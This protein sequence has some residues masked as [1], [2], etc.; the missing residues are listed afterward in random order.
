MTTIKTNRFVW[1]VPLLIC[2]GLF[3]QS[4]RGTITGVVT[5]ASGAVVP[6][7]KV[8]IT[9]QA[10]N[11]ALNVATNATGAYTL[12]SVPPGVYTVRTEKQGFKASVVNGLVVNAASTVRSDATLEIG[13]STQAVEVQ[14]AAVQLQTQDAKSS[15]TLENALV[16]DLPLVVGGTVRTPFDLAALTPGAKN[17]GGDNGFMLGGGQAAAYGTSL[18]GVSTNTSR[19]LSMSWVASNSPSVEAIQEFTS[20]TNGFKAE[21]GHAGGGNLT[22]VSKS[23]T[24][25]YHGSAYEFLRNNDFDANN[26]FSNRSGIPN[27]IYK[28]NDFGATVGGPVTIPK[29]YHGKDKT[30]FFFSYEGFRN[31]TGANGSNFTVPTSEMYNGDF[32]KWV[33]AS[34]ALIP[35][36]DPASQV[37]NADGTYTRQVFPGNQIP[38]NRFNPVAVKALNVF[39]TGGKL[40]PNN[41]A[42]PGTAAYVSNN[43][44]VT[45]GTQVYPVNKWS[46]K[47]DQALTSKH[48]FSFYY[49]YDREHQTPGPDGPATLPGLYTSYNDLVQNTDVFRLA[50]DWMIGPNKLNHFYAGGNNW[51]QGHNPPQEYIGNWKSKFCLGNVPDCNDN[52]VN[53]FYGGTGN[54]YSQWGGNANNGSENPAY[55]FNDDFSLIKGNHTFKFGGMYQLNNYSGFGR[56]CEAGCVGF[57]YQETGLPGGSN[58][59][60]GGNAFAS[61]LLGYADSGQIDTVRYIAQNFPYFGGYFQDDWRV[62][63]KLVLNLGLR[64]DISLPPTGG[65]GAWSDFSPTTPNPGAGGLPGAIL[66]CCSGT[67]R[68]G[69]AAL[70]DLWT[71]GLG[72][73]I[74]FAYSKDAKTVLRGSYSRSYGGLVSVSGSTHNMGFTLTQTFSNSS[75]GLNP[76]FMLDQGMPP[77]TAPPFVNPAV[78]NG[79]SPSW[80]Q[81]MDATKL[82]ATDNFN[83]SIQR[84]IGNS[85]VVE[86]GYNGVM[87]EHLQS[88]LLGYNQISPSYLTKF[89]TVAQSTTVLTSLVG[90]ATANAAGVYAPWS[91]FN[92]LWGSRATVAQALRPWPQYNTIDTYAGEGDHSGH[93]TYH[94]MVMKLNKRMANGLTFQASYVFS[95]ILTDSDTAWGSGRAADLFNRGLEKSIGQ[96]DVTHDFKFAGFYDLPFGKGQR[97]VGSGPAAWIIGNWRLSGVAVYDSGTPLSVSTSLSLPIFAGRV[98]AYVTSYD[99][100]T[101][102]Y[103]GSFDPSKDNRF[104]AY[105]SGPFPLQGSGTGL[106]SIGNETR[107]NPKIRNFPNLNENLSI[108]RTFPIRE[109]VRLEFRAEAFNIFNRVRFGTG[110][111]TL[112]S[113]SFGVLTGSGSQLNSPRQLQLALKLYF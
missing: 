87:G 21:S 110:S 70:G 95:K 42:A 104:V 77:W 84:E 93:S 38:Q 68:V 61:F 7:A 26:F 65:S 23:G 13:T 79:S 99:G 8:T 32:S 76:T 67:G 10:T 27:S 105:G 91:G 5:D 52:L 6:D 41:G 69:T 59:N 30:F 49:G 56:Q 40:A 85:V 73:H 31:R 51:Q 53:L 11:V 2:T 66:F 107:Y 109:K 14:A 90:S 19:A 55:S 4:E 103:S 86:V 92:T 89:G 43:Y 3:G 34:G 24:N 9:N 1:I 111:T 15:T 108:T 46:I 101:P 58:S 71:K 54:T 20:E 60:A 72:P 57:S 82:P 100:W 64:Y 17:L 102:S 97:F 45:S 44:L 47:F 18:D 37:Q 33:T 25:Q 63:P 48:H 50:W 12:A 96:F 36:Y 83:F 98:P 28:Q 88:Q 16:N 62:T 112:Q 94:A 75:N 80:F 74:G 78:A 81:G 29:L 113:Q 106:N 22:Y 39:Q 35:I